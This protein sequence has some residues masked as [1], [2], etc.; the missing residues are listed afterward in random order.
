MRVRSYLSLCTA[1]NQ[2][3]TQRFMPPT[4]LDTHSTHPKQGHPHPAKPKSPRKVIMSA[5]RVW[6]EIPQIR[7]NVGV[8][9]RGRTWSI[10]PF[11]SSAEHAWKLLNTDLQIQL[12]SDEWT[13]TCIDLSLGP[14]YL[15][16]FMNNPPPSS[17]VPSSEKNEFF[18]C[19]PIFGTLQPRVAAPIEVGACWIHCSLARG[20]RVWV[21]SVNADI[22]LRTHVRLF[23]YLQWNPGTIVLR[24]TGSHCPKRGALERVNSVTVTELICKNKL[25]KGGLIRK[26][27]PGS[28]LLC[29]TKTKT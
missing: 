4:N 3:E 20:V 14:D 27:L 1:S 7:I 29:K 5:G 19:I 26:Y 17:K 21:F 23:I 15:R 24:I 11:Y 6:A 12:L 9:K 18:H 2:T 22:C 28:L 10:L 25:E 16:E 13:T 8:K